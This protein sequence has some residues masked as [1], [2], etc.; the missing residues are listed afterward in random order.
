M[1]IKKR[2]EKKPFLYMIFAAVLIALLWHMNDIKAAI[3]DFLNVL[4]P[5]FASIC[6]A[7][8][9][10]P[11]S[12]KVQKV[13]DKIHK[14]KINRM[15]AILLT[16][17]STLLLVIFGMIYMIP[18]LYT[19][20]VEIVSKIPTYFN[21]VKELL[22]KLHIDTKGLNAESV[23]MAI[24]NFIGEESS[25]VDQVVATT[26]SAISGLINALISTIFAL[27]ILLDKEHIFKY[28][29][30]LGDA[31]FGEEKATAI[32]KNI[33]E[34]SMTINKFLVGKII[35]SI[36]IGIIAFV[37]LMAFGFP[38]ALL[39]AVTIGLTNVI[40]DIGPF[41]G[42]I[43]G[44]L[45]YSSI[46]LKTAAI[47][48]VIVLAIQQF[49]GYI[50]GPRIIGAKLGIRPIVILP[51]VIIGGHYMGI[52]G[53]V[54]GVPIL[55]TCNLYLSR[56]IDKRIEARKKEKSNDEADPS[57]ENPAPPET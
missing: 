17:F 52:L 28:I 16:Y 22:E 35:D 14:F 49:D 12:Q 34:C 7:Y 10:Y 8:I 45:I 4:K 29:R 57:D 2:F 44:I 6:I 19:S 56:W 23:Q 11:I 1:N 51:A 47:F 50:L 24:L 15:V 33:D 32:A 48:G 39:V 3:H 37:V 30:R 38:Y 40:P 42:A 21:E 27:Y 55:S 46:D 53:A 31:V 26:T 20:I 43:P 9:L 41:I 5:F 13:L 54:L 18:E 36:I 25:M